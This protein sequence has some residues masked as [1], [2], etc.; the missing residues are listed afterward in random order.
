MKKGEF[1]SFVKHVILFN[2]NVYIYFQILFD[3]LKGNILRVII[4]CK[5]VFKEH[6]LVSPNSRKVVMSKFCSTFYLCNL[7]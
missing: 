7:C 2:E 5:V 6:L 4:L 1:R 3:K